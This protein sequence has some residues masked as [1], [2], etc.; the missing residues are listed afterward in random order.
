[1]ID[2]KDFK[3][4]IVCDFDNHN[5]A[6]HSIGI[7]NAPAALR[8]NIC[9]QC[10]IEIIEEALKRLTDEEKAGILRNYL[11]AEKTLEEFDSANEH[12]EDRKAE[13]NAKSDSER[14]KAYRES[15]IARAKELGIS[16]KIATFSNK[17]LEKEIRKMEGDNHDNQ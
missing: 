1:M 17:T 13:K 12:T 2:I 3:Y 9:T 6:S 7:V 15:L 10:L 5:I 11:P 8:T 14:R 4:H 16:G